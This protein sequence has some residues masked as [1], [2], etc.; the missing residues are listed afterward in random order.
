MNVPP[1][2][3]A[4]H[5]RVSEATL[6]FKKSFWNKKK[7]LDDCNGSEGAYFIKDR[8]P[9]CLELEP[10]EIIVSLLHSSNTS[11]KDLV[12]DEPNG[13]HFNFSNNLFSF[14]I[15]LDNTKKELI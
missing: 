11:T 5:E 8:Y 12:I 15:K 3:D 4:F 9:E 14:I 10:E 13:C 6:C 1:H 2:Q 7:F